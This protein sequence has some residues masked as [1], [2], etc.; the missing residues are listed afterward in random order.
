MIKRYNTPL[1]PPNINNNTHKNT[2]NNKPTNITQVYGIINKTDAAGD[3]VYYWGTLN[4]TAGVHL[5]GELQN[6]PSTNAC[7]PG[8]MTL[9]PATNTV[10]AFYGLGDR[11]PGG[12]LSWLHINATTG[13]IKNQWSWSSDVLL[14]VWV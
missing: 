10:Y 1:L 7:Q 11:C 4:G 13:A 12:S 6:L 5:I 3:T 9:N 14:L 8:T 2:H